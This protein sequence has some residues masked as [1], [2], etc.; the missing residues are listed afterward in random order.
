MFIYKD[1]LVAPLEL[2]IWVESNGLA[3]IGPIFWRVGAVKLAARIKSGPIGHTRIGPQPI[4]VRA[5]PARLARNFFINFLII[6][7]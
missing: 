2:G 6:N 4:R 1:A 7:F 3:R 5:G